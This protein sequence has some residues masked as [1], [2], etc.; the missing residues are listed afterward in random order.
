MLVSWV[1]PQQ[2]FCISLIK[3]P[4]TYVAVQSFI[5]LVP[6]HSVFLVP[7]KA[8]AALLYDPNI[9]SLSE[10]DPFLPVRISFRS[11]PF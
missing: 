2:A 3:E 10:L 8:R 6:L 7:S 1:I 4:A 5:L 9:I 11:S